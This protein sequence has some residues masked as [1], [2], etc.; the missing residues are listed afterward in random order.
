M[1][2][3]LTQLE[4]E[5]QKR[6]IQLRDADQ[7]KIFFQLDGWFKT[8]SSVKEI[9]SVYKTDDVRAKEYTK[10]IEKIMQQQKDLDKRQNEHAAKQ[11]LLQAIIDKQI[12]SKKQ[13]ERE[14]KKNEDLL[15]RIQEEERQQELVIRTEQE[16][17]WEQVVLDQRMD[18]VEE[19][20][21]KKSHC[22]I[23]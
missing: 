23:S 12:S 3:K 4:K 19:G 15:S 21:K 17:L 22:S 20:N 18:S 5:I 14:I 9:E 11:K 13:L 7:K 1:A 6:I 2:E 8:L 10:L 16:V